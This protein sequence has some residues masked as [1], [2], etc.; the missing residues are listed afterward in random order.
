M[1]AHGGYDMFA[2]K[3]I[4]TPT[5][6]ETETELADSLARQRAAY[7]AAQRGDTAAQRQYRAGI[8]QAQLGMAQG[9]QARGLAPSQ[10]RAAIYAGGQMQ[11]RAAT[12]SEILRA[13]ELEAARQQYIAAQRGG[14]AISQQWQEVYQ[15]ARAAQEAKKTEE[16]AK[17]QAAT[18]AGQIPTERAVAM[19]IQ[20]FFGGVGG[21]MASDVRAKEQIAAP[22]GAA[23]DRTIEGLRGYEYEYRPETRQMLGAAMAPR[24][25]R[26]GIMA[27]DLERTPLGR[28]M[29]DEGPAGKTIDMRAAT[30]GSLALIG[31]LGERVEELERQKAGRRP[32]A[33]WAEEG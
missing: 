33:R 22:P 12:E 2:H 24:G 30:M 13:Q 15:R 23:E 25:D 29:V 20:G 8:E 9:A 21:G 17:A 7:E 14:V 3:R 28:T 11:A 31:R 32:R 5:A 10:G 27:Q 16:Y 1:A 19:G 26:Y 4:S 6:V 18:E